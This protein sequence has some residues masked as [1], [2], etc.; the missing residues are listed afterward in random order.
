MRKNYLGKGKGNMDGMYKGPEATGWISRRHVE[1]KEGHCGWDP[2]SKEKTKG[3]LRAEVRILN[4][5][6]RFEFMLRFK[7]EYES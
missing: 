4:F 7:C 3:T 5:I 2:Q 6:L 1:L